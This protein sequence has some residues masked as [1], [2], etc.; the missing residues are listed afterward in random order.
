MGLAV[1]EVRADEVVG[2]CHVDDEG[3]L[4]G[5][6]SLEVAGLADVLADPDLML[7][8]GVGLSREGLTGPGEEDDD[9]GA[10]SG[11]TG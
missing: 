7:P 4:T 2:R 3:L 8:I 10:N 11:G 1:G 6:E 9:G 5:L